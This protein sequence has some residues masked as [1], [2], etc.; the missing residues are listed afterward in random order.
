MRRFLKEAQITGQL[1]HPN[2]VP[3]YELARRV[4]DDQPYYTMRLIRGRTL[5]RAIEDFH[6]RRAAGAADPLEWPR[7]LQA[8]VGVCQAI[9]YA[10]SRGVIHRDLKPENVVLGAFGEVILLDWG[11]AKMV[12]S[13]DEDGDGLPDVTLT[14]EAQAD[15]TM[16]GQRLGTPAY[17]APEQAEGR[18]DLVDALTDIY[19]LAQSCSRS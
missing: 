16:A 10:H 5:H 9:A 1:E 2:I 14:G 6:T 13:P 12:D 4:E 11:L 17:M 18:T 7:L 19:G 15:S 8:F 3:V